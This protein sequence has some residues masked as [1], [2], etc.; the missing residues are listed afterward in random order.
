MLSGFNIFICIIN[1][2]ILR[3]I[4]FVENTIIDIL[5]YI[6]LNAIQSA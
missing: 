4:V 5:G 6:K 2:I 3:N 1:E